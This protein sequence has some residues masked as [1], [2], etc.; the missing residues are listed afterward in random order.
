M[1]LL[2]EFKI[3]AAVFL[4]LVFIFLPFILNKD[5]FAC[6]IDPSKVDMSVDSCTAGGVTVKISAEGGGE[7]SPYPHTIDYTVTAVEGV[8]Q[9]GRVSGE[10]PYSCNISI[11]ASFEKTVFV[12]FS[13]APTGPV[14]VTLVLESWGLVSNYSGTDSVL[15][16]RAQCNPER[17]ANGV[18]CDTGAECKS[19]YCDPSNGICACIPDGTNVEAVG[20]SCG[21][22]CSGSCTT[23][24]RFCKTRAAGECANI[25]EDCSSAW[26]KPCCITG[27]VECKYRYSAPGGSL[28]E[29]KTSGSCKS[30]GNICGGAA[31]SSCCPDGSGNPVNCV[32]TTGGRYQCGGDTF[33][34]GIPP[35]IEYTGPILNL[36]QIVTVLYRI[37]FPIGVAFG[38][39]MVI[40]AGYTIMTS[41]GE[42]AKVTEAKEDLT[43]AVV[44]LL[45][46]LLS[47]VILRVIIS[48][49]LGADI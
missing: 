16:Q 2:K 17:N 46:V 1:R 30:W 34:W 36:E 13:K 20:G 12:P 32:A 9:T 38:A 22:C 39:F 27:S 49:L 28:C 26:G 21:D 19:F 41:E 18:E 44:G 48:S 45:F 40:K 11:G 24:T 31:D 15:L 10:A 4:F 8:T 47:A 3:K 35:L 7:T 5:V 33:D 25:G 42:P 6:P 23:G 29:R 43:A 14:L 37:L